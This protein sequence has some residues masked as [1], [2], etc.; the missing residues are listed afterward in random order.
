VKLELA[1]LSLSK[2]SFKTSRVGVMQT[3]AKDE[4]AT[5]FWQLYEHCESALILA[6]TILRKVR[7]K[8]LSHNFI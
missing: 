3:I 7:N 1:G 2:D 8:H 6:M 4:F 5:A